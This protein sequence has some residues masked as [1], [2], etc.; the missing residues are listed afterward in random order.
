MSE[1]QLLQKRALID[2]QKL[3]RDAGVPIE[4]LLADHHD[5]GA[6]NCNLQSST[7]NLSL[8]PNSGFLTSTPS[9]EFSRASYKAPRAELDGSIQYTRVSYAAAILDHPIDAV[10]EFPETGRFEGEAIA[11]Q[12]CVDASKLISP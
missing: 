7:F 9:S 10:V 12:F 11:H 8:T 5:L 3:L 4:A 1:L 2:A 6:D